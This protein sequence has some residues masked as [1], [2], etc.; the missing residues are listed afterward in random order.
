MGTAIGQSLPIAVGVLVSPMPIVAL[1][2]MLVSGRARSNGLAFV[3]GW[4]VG[5]FLV[6]LVVALAAGAAKGDDASSPAWLG[7]LKIVLGVLLLLVGVR[8][9]QGRPRDGAQ[10]TTPG[11][12]ASLDSFTPVKAAGLAFAL[13]AINPKN[14]LLVASGGAAIAAA[15]T[16]TG[17]RVVAMVVFTVV[18]SLGVIV[19][20]VIYLVMGDRAADLL[21][22]VKTWMIQNNAVIMAVLML[23][24]GVKI[25]GDGISTL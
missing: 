18:A 14:L 2:L 11:W 21:D 8:Q 6:G 23:V 15:T 9:W 24:L 17:D 4:V 19:P 10:S 5:V 12:M 1:V 20:F 13:G 25:L 3:V 22:H 7:W 16:S